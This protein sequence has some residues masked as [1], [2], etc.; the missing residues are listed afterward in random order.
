MGIKSYPPLPL[1]NVFISTAA[2]AEKLRF[3]KFWQNVASGLSD[4]TGFGK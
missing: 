1:I 3:A 4:A 2:A